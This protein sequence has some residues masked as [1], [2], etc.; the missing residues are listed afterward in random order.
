MF[1]EPGAAESMFAQLSTKLMFKSFLTYR[2]PNPLTGSALAGFGA[3]KELPPWLTEEDVNYFASK[4]EKSGFTGGLNYY[5]NMNWYL[6][7]L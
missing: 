2:D 7:L 6:F 5:R 1:Q 3:D 4:F